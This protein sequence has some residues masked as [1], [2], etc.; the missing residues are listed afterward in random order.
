MGRRNSRLSMCQESS[1]TPNPIVIFFPFCKMLPYFP[2]EG[3]NTLKF[4]TS[5]QQWLLTVQRENKG[6]NLSIRKWQVAFNFA[7]FNYWW[8]WLFCICFCHLHS[9]LEELL[10]NCLC[11]FSWDLRS[12]ALLY[13]LKYMLGRID[14]LSWT[15]IFSQYAF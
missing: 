8:N 13:L 4:Y 9:S 7:L 6:T 1:P 11:E 12:Y 15:E 10:I 14:P 2:L 3:C 5:T